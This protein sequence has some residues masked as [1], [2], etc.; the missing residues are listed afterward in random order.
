MER[1][2]ILYPLFIMVILTFLVIYRQFFINLHALKQKDV[3]LSFF[4]LFKFCFT[5]ALYSFPSTLIMKPPRILGSTM[6]FKLIDLMACSIFG[7][8]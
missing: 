5:L 7:W 1:Q 4:K 3:K 2:E 8:Y 6:F